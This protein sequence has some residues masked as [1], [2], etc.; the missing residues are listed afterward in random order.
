MKNKLTRVKGEKKGEI[1]LYALSTC[2]WCKKTRELLDKLGIEYYFVYVDLL[3]KEDNAAI[4]SELTRW[5]PQCSFPTIVVNNNSCI[6]GFKED[7]IKEL[8]NG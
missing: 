3:N 2:G 6:V 5:N 8:A 7:K 1:F 4:K